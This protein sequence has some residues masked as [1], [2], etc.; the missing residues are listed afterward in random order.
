VG[1]F[2]SQDSIGYASKDINLY[3]YVLNSPVNYSDSTG[4]M[5]DPTLLLKEPPAPKPTPNRPISPS[6]KPPVPNPVP[7]RPPFS[8]IGVGKGVVI[9]LLQDLIFPA[10]GN[11]GED[12]MLEKLR[13]NE[14]D[15]PL[16]EK[17]NWPRRCQLESQ[18]PQPF[19]E[20]ELCLYRCKDDPAGTAVYAFVPLGGKCPKWINWVP[21]DRMLDPNNLPPDAIP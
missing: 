2:L 21:G 7:I 10:P 20:R 14:L 16:R 19:L 18:A 11:N 3:R 1:R 4:Q 15:P 13:C 9:D 6:K 5:P 12:E 17:E 8:W